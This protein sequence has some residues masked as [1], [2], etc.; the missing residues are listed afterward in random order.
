MTVIVHRNDGGMD[1]GID[2]GDSLLKICRERRNSATS[3]QRISDKG[4]TA[5]TS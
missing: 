4:Y 2:G 1:A 5:R 3:R